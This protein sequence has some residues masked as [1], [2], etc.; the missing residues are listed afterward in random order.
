MDDVVEWY[1]HGT[2]GVQVWLDPGPAGRS[3][4]VLEVSDLDRRTAELEGEGLPYEG[5]HAATASRIAQPGDPDGNRI[6]ITGA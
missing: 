6:V 5:P 1:L 2:F 3:T 4:G